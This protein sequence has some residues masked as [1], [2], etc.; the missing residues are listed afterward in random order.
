MADLSN[1]NDMHIKTIKKL[2]AH[3]V[4]RKNVAELIYAIKNIDLF[5]EDLSKHNLSDDKIAELVDYTLEEL[6]RELLE[7]HK[8]DLKK[9]DK[10][11]Q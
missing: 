5:I 9:Y 2:V 7:N 1:I 8:E 6:H 4:E 10:I 3:Q 11:N